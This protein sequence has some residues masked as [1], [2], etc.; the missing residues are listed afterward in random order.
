MLCNIGSAG[1][2]ASGASSGIVVASPDKTNPDCK[3]S[4]FGQEPIPDFEQTFTPGHATLLSHSSVSWTLSSTAILHLFKPK[5]KTTL[6]LKL[7]YKLF[8]ILPEVFLV[9]ALENPN[10]TPMRVL[11]LDPGAARREMDP[12]F[13]LLP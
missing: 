3:L 6:A 11:S 9:V 2:C 7:T 13:V 4:Y 12:L 10:S 8:R 1:A 5:L